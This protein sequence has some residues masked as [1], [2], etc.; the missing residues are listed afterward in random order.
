MFK[1][2]LLIFSVLVTT[3]NLFGQ[4]GSSVSFIPADGTILGQTYGVNGP[5]GFYMGTWSQ[6]EDVYRW[7]GGGYPWISRVGI[8]CSIYHNAFNVGVGTKFIEGP[9]GED[10][11]RPHGLLTF[12]PVRF[13]T[14]K[15]QG[16]DLA[17]VLD[18]SDQV[19]YGVGILVPFWLNRY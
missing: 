7:G 13:F 17:L 9:N 12:H 19:N 8:N 10:I 6:Y 15:N 1:K 11:I 3:V 14:R 4:S 16:V 5:L 18:I 2:S